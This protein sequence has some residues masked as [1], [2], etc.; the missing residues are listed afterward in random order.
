MPANLKTL[1][2]PRKIP[3]IL[4]TGYLCT[5]EGSDSLK[6]LAGDVHIERR[7]FDENLNYPEQKVVT[8]GQFKMG[9]TRGHQATPW[10]QA[11]SALLQRRLDVDILILGHARMT[12]AFEHETAFYINPGSAAG[13]HNALETNVILPSL[14]MDIKASTVVLIVYGFYLLEESE[15][16]K[17]ER[18]QRKKS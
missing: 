11:S 2:V 15:K 1:V 7:N 12:E 8:I 16:K 14:L 9:L 18:F 13:A 10:G 5:K 3:H 4:C 6:T 17:K